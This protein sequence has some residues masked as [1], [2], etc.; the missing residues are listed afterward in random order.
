MPAEIHINATTAVHT[1]PLSRT[2]PS[3]TSH[4]KSSSFKAF[5]FDC[6]CTN[7]DLNAHRPLP[8]RISQEVPK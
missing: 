6:D 4:S 5:R 7:C 3:L 8:I 1:L 2:F